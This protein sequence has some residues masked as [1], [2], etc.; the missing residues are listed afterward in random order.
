MVRG[1]DTPVIWGLFILLQLASVPVY[2]AIGS[3]LWV[4]S[5]LFYVAW[6]V[7]MHELCLWLEIQLVAQH[8]SRIYA[9]QPC[10]R[11]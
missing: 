3:E 8:W 9:I 7:A 2:E 4:V 5:S 6:T 10:P 1:F 11:P